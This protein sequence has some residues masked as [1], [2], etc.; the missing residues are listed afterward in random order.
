MWQVLNDL[1]LVFALCAPATSVNLSCASRF[2]QLSIYQVLTDTATSLV[3]LARKIPPAVAELVHAVGH[4]AKAIQQVAI[5][6]QITR[7]QPCLVHSPLTSLALTGALCICKVVFFVPARCASAL[8]MLLDSVQGSCIHLAAEILPN[9]GCS[10]RSVPADPVLLMSRASLEVWAM[11]T[12]TACL[13]YRQLVPATAR[14]VGC[15]RRLRGS[16]PRAKER[17]FAKKGFDEDIMPE[18]EMTSMVRFCVHSM[19]RAPCCVALQS[20]GLR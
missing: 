17:K 1:L 7:C 13:L 14:L 15:Y 16:L 11:S 19:S 3:K 20:I 5:P 18:A 4:S 10:S 2:A 9:H 8:L 12:P 6:C